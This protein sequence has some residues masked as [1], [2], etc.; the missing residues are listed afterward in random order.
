MPQPPILKAID[1]MM[2]KLAD[3]VRI[4]R[5]S[6]QAV[7]EYADAIRALA[8]VCEDEETKMNI[9]LAVEDVT[10]KPG[11]MQAIRSVLR[12]RSRMMLTA[13]DIK[14]WILM[15]RKMN[16]S[17]YSNPMASIHTTLRRLKDKGEIEETTNEK[18]ERAYRMKLK[19]LVKGK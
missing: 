9:L 16:L 19:E 8:Q 11:F 17:G 2:A 3:A 13:S 15:D 6:E 10:G 4:N 1:D 14:S 7:R 18:G 5:E 12:E